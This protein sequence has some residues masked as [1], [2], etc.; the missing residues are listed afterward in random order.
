MDALEHESFEHIVKFLIPQEFCSFRSFVGPS[1]SPEIQK[2]HIRSAQSADPVY[3]LRQSRSATK[4]SRPPKVVSTNRVTPPHPAPSPPTP[5]GTQGD[6]KGP[7]GPKGA[8]GAL[9][10]EWGHGAIWGYSEAISNRKPFRMEGYYEWEDI[11][12]REL[13]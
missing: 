10:G 12:K 2:V 9:G 8:F 5:K 3:Y 1:S 4:P 6:S 13:I 7:R 11:L